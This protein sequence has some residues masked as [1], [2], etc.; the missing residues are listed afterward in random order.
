MRP[1]SL[2]L[3]GQSS[4]TLPQSSERGQ[5]CRSVVIGDTAPAL[6]MSMEVTLV[7]VRR[8][9]EMRER[10]DFR[11]WCSPARSTAPSLPGEPCDRLEWRSPNGLGFCTG[12]RLPRHARD[13]ERA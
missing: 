12:T 2:K 6:S 13:T 4:P 7:E 3:E 5:A 10:P 11:A 8:P 1:R 9:C